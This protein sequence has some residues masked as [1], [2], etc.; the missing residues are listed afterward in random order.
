MITAGT[1]TPCEAARVSRYLRIL[2]RRAALLPFLAA[3]VARLPIAMGPLGIVIL[4]QQ[5][6]GAYASAGLVTAAFAVGSSVATPIWGRLM[7]R[8]GQAVVIGPVSLVSGALL[9]TLAERAVHGA[10]DAALAALAAGCGITFP[11]I[12]PAMRGAWRSVLDQDLDR[13]AAYALDAVAVE[14]IFVGG[15]LLLSLLL[16]FAPPVVPLLVT[17]GLLA[18]GGFGYALT[19]AARRWCPEP[20]E[21][22]HGHR[23]ASPLRIP[24]V[25]LVLGVSAALS[26]GFGLCDVSIAA[27]ARQVLGDQ[28]KV[29]L[30]FAAIAGGSATGGLWYGSRVWRRPERNRL[31][32]TL[33]GF[34]S[35]LFGIGVLLATRLTTPWG[36]LPAMV[37][38]LFFTGLNIAPGLIMLANQ[39]DLHGPRDRLSEA[40]S[41]LNTSFTS[42][43]ALGTAAAGVLVDVGGPA[44]GFL[45]AGTAVV[46]AVL[47]AL[48]VSRSGGDEVSVTPL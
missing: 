48:M 12:S 34:A 27:T 28:A 29:G 11:P 18:C 23:G 38:L 17:A 42:G 8:R 33:S 4:V 14:T 45:G 16:V 21:D 35:G 44:G 20:H 6:R 30:L 7:D 32:I 22:G 10:P 39:I 41:W 19:G 25:L 31:P 15:P 46:A 5:V 3:V 13:R 24:A 2:S 1:E 36:T 26:V 40:Q 37:P 43:G 47:V 9:A